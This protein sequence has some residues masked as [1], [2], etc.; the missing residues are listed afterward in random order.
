MLNGLPAGREAGTLSCREQPATPF[1]LHLNLRH[2]DASLHRLHILREPRN[3]QVT[4]DDSPATNSEL[5]L[6]LRKLLSTHG[7][8]SLNNRCLGRSPSS[9]LI[10]HLP[11]GIL[12]PPTCLNPFLFLSPQLCPTQFYLK[13]WKIHI[14]LLTSA[15]T[16][17]PAVCVPAVPWKQSD[18]SLHTED[19]CFSHHRARLVWREQGTVCSPNASAICKGL[20]S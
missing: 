11:S 16:T 2:T 9:V 12:L 10:P 6:G 15:V 5:S 4:D 18:P 13:L 3:S 17:K 8:P 7:S 20:K 1:V 19:W 14:Y